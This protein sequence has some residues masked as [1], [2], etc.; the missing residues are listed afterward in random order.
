M[1]M[2]MYAFMYI[3]ICFSGAPSPPRGTHLHVRK[4]ARGLT[5][6]RMYPV[7]QGGVPKLPCFTGVS[8]E[9]GARRA[10]D[11]GPDFPS[12]RRSHAT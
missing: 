4:Q 11:K 1:Y 5:L 7:R 6:V 8:T 3:R 2:Y 10:R 9:I 12:P